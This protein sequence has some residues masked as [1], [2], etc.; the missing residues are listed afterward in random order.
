MI[1][2][3]VVERWNDVGIFF[4]AHYSKLKDGPCI[5][6]SY[7]AL[8]SFNKTKAPEPE[9]TETPESESSEP[10]ET[11]EEEMLPSITLLGQQL[12]QHIVGMNPTSL[13]DPEAKDEEKDRSKQLLHQEFLLDSGM[14]VNQFLIENGIEVKD[15][16]RFQCG[17]ELP[18]DDDS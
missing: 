15:F 9:S 7:G 14:T 11:S 4:A 6:G 5:L 3:E 12:S 16:V 13:G 17:E 2:S 1:A 10:S 18:S 8:V